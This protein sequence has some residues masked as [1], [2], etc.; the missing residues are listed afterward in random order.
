MKNTNYISIFLLIIFSSLIYSQEIPNASFENWNGNNLDGW[1]IVNTQLYINVSQSSIAHS[2]SSS[3]RGEIIEFSFPPAPPVPAIPFLYP[4][5]AVNPSFPVSQ[6]YAALNG[7]YQFYPSTPN[8]LLGP[9]FVITLI[10]AQ[11]GTV[12][13][14]ET[15]LLSETISTWQS[16]TIPI[17]YSVGNSGEATHAQL[18]IQIGELEE[19]DIPAA[20]GTYFLLD[21][22]SFTGIAGITKEDDIKVSE[23]SLKQNYPNPFNP[24]TQI[25][26]SIP[27]TEN[28]KLDV[29][30]LLGQKVASLVN[31]NLSAGSYTTDWNAENLSSGTY[32][33]KMTA[34]NI[35]Q[36]KKMVLIK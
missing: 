34:G 7:Y 14:T 24:T 6:N 5:T 2:G 21:D 19:D 35:V 11:G 22:L 3:L 10:D 16:F 33:Y 15:W 4:G 13:Q 23:F 8:L 32:I 28:V 31:D 20:Y 30:N 17:D 36:S 25:N 29:Y 18:E 27:K 26:F 1:H 9:H 12:A